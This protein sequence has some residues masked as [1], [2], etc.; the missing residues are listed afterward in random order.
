MN[1]TDFNITNRHGDVIRG[2]I[3]S[4]DANGH[5]PLAIICH[6]FKGFKDWGMFPHAADVLA[7]RGITAIRFNFSL[8]GVGEDPLNFTML[9]R[10]ERNTVSREIDDLGDLIDA[11]TTGD[12]AV[13]GT[14]CGKLAVIGHSLGAGVCI[15]KTLEDVRIRAAVSWAGVASFDRWGPKFKKQWREQGRMEILNQR[16]NQLMPMGIA[17]LNDLE[18]NETRFDVC[19]AARELRRPLLLLHGEQDVS[20]PI[21]EGQRIREA[22]DP[23]LTTMHSIPN[24]DH[25]F[26]AVHPFAGSTPALEQLLELT[27]GWLKQELL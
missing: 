3:H 11:V 19:G 18:E 26:G 10:F 6:G 1:S 12:L 21:E 15:V 8:N 20:V 7:S 2:N 24:A 16:T 14:D 13:P 22:A 4:A 23:S 25:T 27:S 5:A 17:M 9:D